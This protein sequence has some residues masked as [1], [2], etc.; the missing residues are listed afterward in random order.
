ME[1]KVWS[2][3]RL[4]IMVAL[5]FGAQLWAINHFSARPELAP[6]AP[7]DQPVVSFNLYP[8]E[9]GSDEIAA[10]LLAEDPTVLALPSACGFT[11]PSWLGRRR[12][13]YRPPA[14]LDP[15]RFLALDTGSIGRALSNFLRENSF[16]AFD[17]F[18]KD[19]PSPAATALYVSPDLAA[20][21][22][23]ATIEGDLA[24]RAP[25]DFPALASWPSAQVVTNSRVRVSVNAAGTVVSAALVNRSGQPAADAAA[26]QIAQ[27]VR[28]RPASPASLATRPDAGPLAW[29]DIVFS[30]AWTPP[31]NALPPVAG[32][33]P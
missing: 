33:P 31:T 11:G 21:Q 14:S 24:P 12:V 18:E 22:S 9:L 23:V 15:P 5:L 28:F 27:R 20:T 19:A 32:P 4:W 29:G 3:R 8:G 7:P 26:L 25:D 17:P 30:W 6:V 2:A 13:N 16:P 1:P 10:D